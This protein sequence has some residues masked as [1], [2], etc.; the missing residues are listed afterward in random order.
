MVI[1]CTVPPMVRVLTPP[2]G[3][4]V[5]PVR[6]TAPAVVYAAETTDEGVKPKPEG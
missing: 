4:M 5:A 3:A 2:V 6:V 1:I